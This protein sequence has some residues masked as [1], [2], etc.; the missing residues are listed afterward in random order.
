MGK[1]FIFRSANVNKFSVR[2]RIKNV[3]HHNGRFPDLFIA[4][5]H[6]TQPPHARLMTPVNWKKRKKIL[7]RISDKAKQEM[8][9][10]VGDKQSP[11]SILVSCLVY[12]PTL[13]MEATCSFEMSAD[14]Q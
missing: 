12:S 3:D 13:K 8:C 14:F 11:A 4:A 1:N 9:V 2:L 7:R 10:K 5:E 6:R